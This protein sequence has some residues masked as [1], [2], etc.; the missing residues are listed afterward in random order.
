MKGSA[1]L[2]TGG[3][4]RLGRAIALALAD[5]GAD[6]AVHYHHSAEDAE[7]TCRE[8]ERAGVRAWGIRADLSRFDETEALFSTAEQNAGGIT[9]LINNASIFPEHTLTEFTEEDLAQNVRVNAMAPLWLSRALFRTGRQACII[10]LL[11][12]KMIGADDNHAAYHLSK[13]MLLTL[14]RM[15]AREFAPRIRVNAVAPGLILPPEGKDE[16]YVDDLAHT[17]PLQRRGDAADVTAAVVFL[18]ESPFITGQVIYVDG[19]RHLEGN[20]YV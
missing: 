16:R 14:T 11:D 17:L 4:H 1:A 18:A 19:G 8:L 10:N 9:L 2:V 15:M 5:R 12:S 13:R 7:A 6:V 3:A 20:L